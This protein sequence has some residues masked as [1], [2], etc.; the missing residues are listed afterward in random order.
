MTE[1]IFM[2]L[3]KL[4][5]THPLHAPVT[6]VPMGMVIGG[7]TFALFAFFAKKPA[8]FRTA[9]HCYVLALIAVPPTM[10][11]GYMDWQHFYRGAANPY[12]T[13]KIVLGA[14]LFVLSIVNI[15]L[16]SRENAGR[17]VVLAACVA[18]L[19]VAGL[20]G[21]FGGELQYGG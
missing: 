8:L 13:T 21:F 7:C 15:R 19:V 4:G 11:I 2:W 9:M 6:H 14:I 18:S 1:F 12:V 17:P 10:F 20:I 3:E 16:L 5:Y